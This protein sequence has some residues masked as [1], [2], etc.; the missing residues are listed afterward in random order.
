MPLRETVAERTS[1]RVAKALV[2][3]AAIGVT[4][5]APD[6]DEERRGFPA[7]VLA[8]LDQ[9]AEFAEAVALGGQARVGCAVKRN[10]KRNKASGA[11]GMSLCLAAQPTRLLPGGARRWRK[12]GGGPAPD[13]RPFCHGAS[14]LLTTSNTSPD[15]P[16]CC[17]KP[18]SAAWA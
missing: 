8:A 13:A 16:G 7:G 5:I 17:S 18:C 10:K 3:N 14:A 9:A 15:K 1:Q 6:G 12:P 2:A 11:G 4:V